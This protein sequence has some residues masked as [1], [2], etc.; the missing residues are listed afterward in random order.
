MEIN[1]PQ[2]N[3]SCL[4]QNLKKKKKE[5]IQAWRGSTF[6]CRRGFEEYHNLMGKQNNR[7]CNIQGSHFYQQHKRQNVRPSA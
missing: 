3:T 6:D 7:T 4:P 5:F 1:R 2:V